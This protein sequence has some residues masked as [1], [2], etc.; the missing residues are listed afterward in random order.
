M[1]TLLRFVG[2]LMVSALLTTFLGASPASAGAVHGG[3]VGVL[4]DASTPHVLDNK[5]LDLAQVGDRIVV[6]GSFT[7]VRD[8]RRQRRRRR[9]PSPTS[10]PSTRPPAR[11]TATFA[12]G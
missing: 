10:S 8:V 11:W 1:A 3:S 6:A 2:M 5:V 9:S 4:P 12:P 7:Q